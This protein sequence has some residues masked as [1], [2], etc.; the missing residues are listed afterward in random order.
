MYGSTVDQSDEHNTY[1]YV[2]VILKKWELLLI[3]EYVG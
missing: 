2:H 3:N 1:N